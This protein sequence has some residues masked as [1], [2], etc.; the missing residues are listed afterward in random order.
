MYHK[1]VL[2][3]LGPGV[4]VCLPDSCNAEL[5]HST[6]FEIFEY[7][8]KGWLLAVHFILRFIIEQKFLPSSRM[9]A[10]NFRFLSLDDQK[11]LSLWGIGTEDIVFTLIER[12]LCPNVNQCHATYDFLKHF[13]SGKMSSCVI[14]LQHPP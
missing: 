14:G 7:V 12:I 3:V 6:A 11:F 4:G 13:A 2:Y 8:G 10:Q 1:V 5:P 9:V